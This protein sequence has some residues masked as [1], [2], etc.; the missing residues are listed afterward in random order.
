MIVLF[1]V[2]LI[3]FKVVKKANVELSYGLSNF[4]NCTE[5]LQVTMQ[6]K[7]LTEKSEKW[8]FFFD[9]I[10]TDH[11]NYNIGLYR[12]VTPLHWAASCMYTT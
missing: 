3:R 2:F 9:R 11:Y 12:E 1:T 7:T 8:S 5:A 6:L 4:G 10:T